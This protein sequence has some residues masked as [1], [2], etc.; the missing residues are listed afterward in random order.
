MPDQPAA[1]LVDRVDRSDLGGESACM[2]HLL[3]D[4]GA[5]PAPEAAADDA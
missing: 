3:D 2:A 4:D 5:V 1:D